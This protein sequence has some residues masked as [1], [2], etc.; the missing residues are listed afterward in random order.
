MPPHRVDVDVAVVGAGP[1]G[2]SVAAHLRHT[3]ASF[4]IFGHPMRFWLEM[5]RGLFLKSFA[6]ATTICNPEGLTYDG[7]CRERGLESREPCSM[8][9]FAEY[10]LWLQRSL[11]PEVEA[12]DVARIAEQDGS[13][14]LTLAGGEELRA[15]H[16]VV[17]VGLRYFQ[18]LPPALAHLPASLVSHTAQ[19]ADYGHLRSKDV[20][21]IGAGQSALEAATLLHESGARPRLLVRGDGPVFHGRTPV[22]RPLVDRLRD[23]LTVL[24]AGRMHWVLQHFPLLM[25]YVPERRR[26]PF[27][28]GYL[29]PAGAWW[30]R[31]RFEPHVPVHRRTEVISARPA[32]GGV[33][34]GLREDGGLRELRADH[35]V[36]GTGFEVDVARLG[37]LAPDLRQR[38]ARVQGAPRLDRH[39]QSSV[40]GLHFV[41]VLAMYSF[42]PLFRFVAGTAFSAPRVARH[43]ARPLRSQP[44]REVA[45]SGG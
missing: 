44:L 2:L 3:T 4:R 15:R 42:G 41:G 39:F 28:R 38:V 21:V 45:L 34:L 7:W 17:A 40:P 18:R 19:Q 14:H 16:V 37:F 1:Y 35:V 9:S 29:G 11:V 13:F 10:G 30:L 23:P 33:V 22:Q 26:V 43:L 6:F 12:Q 36:A 25:H 32:D 20:C 31:D 5:P 8:E 27:T 24:G